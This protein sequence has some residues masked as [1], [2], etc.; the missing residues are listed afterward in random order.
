MVTIGKTFD[1]NGELYEIVKTLKIGPDLVLNSD[2][3]E[4]AKLFYR[5]EKL[6]KRENIYYFVNLVESIE[7][8]M[9]EEETADKELKLETNNEN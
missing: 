5:A 2:D 7:C 8:E 1:I 3:V 6:F 9:V 4:A